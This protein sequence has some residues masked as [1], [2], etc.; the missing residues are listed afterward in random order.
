MAIYFAYTCRNRINIIIEVAMSYT[1][2]QHIL[3]AYNTLQDAWNTYD[4]FCSNVK[5]P[6]TTPEDII[7]MDVMVFPMKEKIRI[8]DNAYQLALREEHSKYLSAHATE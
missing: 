8:A 7:S 5:K 3:D 4:T 6:P 1:P 2:S